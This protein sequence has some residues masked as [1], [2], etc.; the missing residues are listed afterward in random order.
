MAMKFSKIGVVGA[1]TMGKG[2]AE[3]LAVNGLDVYI[4]E[5]TDEKLDQALQMIEMSLNKQ[6]EKWAITETEKKII[7]AKIHRAEHI[8]QLSDCD[9]VI[10]AIV[11]D[12]EAKKQ[13]FKELDLYCSPKAVL[14][15]NTSSLSLTELANGTT[16][17]GRVIGLHFLHPVAKV[18]LVEII[19]GMKTTEETYTY[20]RDFVEQTI[21]KTGIQVYES[22][23]FVTTRLICTLINESLHTL[24]EGVAS[25]ADIDT[26]MRMGYGF[27]YGPLEMADRFGLDSVCAAMERMFREFGDIKYRPS[28]LLKQM[29]RVEKLGVKT[30]QGFFQYDKDGGRL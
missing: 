30:G 16:E 28:F 15:S 6:I 19:R 22:P 21:Q 3:M 1:G 20:T 7:L 23:G 10:E 5:Q 17:P 9:M 2:I 14:A 13:I 26:A 24:A 27:N 4:V 25:A 12:L 29:V 11:E 18:Q 8:N